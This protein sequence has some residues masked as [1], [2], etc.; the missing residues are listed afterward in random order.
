MEGGQES[1][2]FGF[3]AP[4]DVAPKINKKEEKIEINGS[5]NNG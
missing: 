1:P 3:K 5:V 4:K 2:R